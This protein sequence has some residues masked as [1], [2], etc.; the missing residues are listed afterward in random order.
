MLPAAL[1][2]MS[3]PQFASRLREKMEEAQIIPN[4]KTV[5]IKALSIGRER[6]RGVSG[7]DTPSAILQ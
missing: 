5:E 6:T 3:I 7:L 2:P 1:I 4:V